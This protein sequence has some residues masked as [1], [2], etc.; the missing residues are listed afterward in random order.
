MLLS[1]FL[2]A[3]DASG[4]AFAARFRRVADRVPDSDRGM[5]D[6]VRDLLRQIGAEQLASQAHAAYEAHEAHGQT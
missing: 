2:S 1:P 4:I 3:P 5:A 6:S